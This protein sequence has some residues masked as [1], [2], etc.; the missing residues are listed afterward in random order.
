MTFNPWWLLLPPLLQVVLPHGPPL[1]TSLRN[2]NPTY[3]SSTQLLAVSI[4]IYQLEV[5]WGQG[6][7]ASYVQTPRGAQIN[8]KIQTTVG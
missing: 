1:P 3:V 6:H 2:L 7:S 8:I 5:T 4:F